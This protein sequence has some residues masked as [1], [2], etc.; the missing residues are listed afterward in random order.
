M[1]PCQADNT[2]VAQSVNS[3]LQEVAI[4]NSTGKI[5]VTDAAAYLNTTATK[6]LMLLKS[7]Q[8]QGVETEGTW[9]IDP[10]SLACCKAHGIDMKAD[11]GC[12][13]YCASSRCGC[14]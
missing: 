13:S 8:L 4:M 1:N 7:G 9:V 6:V 3:R 2:L 10:D 5:K 12:A 14:K 11:T